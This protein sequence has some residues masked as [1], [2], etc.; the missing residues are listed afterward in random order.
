MGTGGISLAATP[1]S[2]KINEE[3]DKEFLDAFVNNRKSELVA[4]NDEDTYIQGGKAVSR[5]EPSSRSLVRRKAVRALSTVTSRF[6][7][8]Q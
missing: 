7:F 1:D 5:F 8:S 3:W 2:G 4:Y 6:L